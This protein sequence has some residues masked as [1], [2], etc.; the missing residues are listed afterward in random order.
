MK[1]SEKIEEYKNN[2]YN[3]DY[4]QSFGVD[5]CRFENEEIT[6]SNLDSSLIVGSQFKKI[7]FDQN[8]F[9]FS[10]FKKKY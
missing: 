5:S 10:S 6:Y 3:S 9:C 4:V 1:F 7:V 8:C 2:R